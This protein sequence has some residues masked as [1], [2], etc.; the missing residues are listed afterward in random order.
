[1]KIYIDS[2]TFPAS[3]AL[4]AD[5]EKTKALPR[6]LPAV[7]LQRGGFEVAFLGANQP[8]DIATVSLAASIEGTQ[9]QVVAEIGR[10]SEAE[11]AWQFD[12]ALNSEALV[13]EIA[14]HGSARL[15]V[16]VIV[17]DDTE[18]REWQLVA[19]VYPSASGEANVEQVESAKNFA[20]LAEQAANRA[21]EAQADVAGN[22]LLAVKAKQTATEAANAAI[23]AADNAEVSERNAAE[24]QGAAEQAKT[25]A[26]SAKAA[27]EKAASDA[28][29]TLSNVYTKAEIDGVDTGAE[30]TVAMNQAHE[31]LQ[32][33]RGEIPDNFYESL[34]TILEEWSL[35]PTSDWASVWDAIMEGVKNW[36]GCE[37]PDEELAFTAENSPY[38]NKTTG[39]IVEFRNVKTNTL[40]GGDG[41]ST[42]LGLI[43][44]NFSGVAYF[45]RSKN[46][47][48]IANQMGSSNPIS[49]IAPNAASV[50]FAFSRRYGSDA[51]VRPRTYRLVAPNATVAGY[52]FYV[53]YYAQEIYADLRSST[54]NSGLFNSCTSLRKLTARLDRAT[55]F[56]SNMFLASKNL[57]YMRLY[58]PN[59]LSASGVFK[60]LA[61]DADSICY[62]LDYLPA[63]PVGKGGTGIISFSNADGEI[64]VTEKL[65][66]SISAAE[67]KGWTVELN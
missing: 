14:K 23:E 31:Q 15:R 8:Q 28:Q 10:E 24:S 51:F 9:T 30:L 64:E 61:L 39:A 47:N 16:G 2:N 50:S 57:S 58:A 38:A 11:D 43:P 62:T 33:L 12:F 59:L 21:Q 65:Q 3:P 19:V 40:G 32:A 29:T 67:A 49:I 20:E 46:M 48:F 54:D 52:A 25:D 63:D 5:A 18:R 35:N 7:E 42:N 26:E 53:A 1:M 60:G 6:I 4:Y 41:T 17:E 34:L 27:A 22:A 45:A 55:R 36:R 56:N 44:R 37:N 66:A 13:D